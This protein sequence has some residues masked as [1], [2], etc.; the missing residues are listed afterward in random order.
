MTAFLCDTTTYRFR[1]SLQLL[2]LRFEVFITLEQ[3]GHFLD[4]NSS[5]G[6]GAGVAVAAVGKKP[7]NKKK[8]GGYASSAISFTTYKRYQQ[9]ILHVSGILLW[10]ADCT[11]GV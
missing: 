4:F 5:S 3:A 1:R 11:L 8:R 6:A 2:M 10:L 7:T 9:L